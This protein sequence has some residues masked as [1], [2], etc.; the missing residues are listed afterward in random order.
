M[1]DEM[2]TFI[3]PRSFQPFRDATLPR[4]PATPPPGVPLCARV[5]PL[6]RDST[7]LPSLRQIRAGSG[8][9]NL[10]LD[11]AQHVAH[12]KHVSS[13]PHQESAIEPT[14]SARERSERQ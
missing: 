13:G 3:R 6:L 2:K 4:R 10:A 1:S 14:A 7:E 8:S 9:V 12:G 5:G 11:S